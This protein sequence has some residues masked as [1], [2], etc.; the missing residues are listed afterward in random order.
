MFCKILTMNLVNNVLK[1]TSFGFLDLLDTYDLDCM[2]SILYLPLDN[3]TWLDTILLVSEVQAHC[4]ILHS[5]IVY[6]HLL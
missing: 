2:V 6:N 4:I 1:G 5:Y 3:S